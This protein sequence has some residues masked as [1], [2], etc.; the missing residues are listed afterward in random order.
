MSK[1]AVPI[2]ES[3]FQSMTLYGKSKCEI[4]FGQSNTVVGQELG[5]KHRKLGRMLLCCIYETKNE[6]FKNMS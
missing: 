2:Y 5:R 3:V 4:G 6:F 1:L